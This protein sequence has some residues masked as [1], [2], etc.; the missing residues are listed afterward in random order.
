MNGNSKKIGY[1]EPDV[2]ADIGMA[3]GTVTVKR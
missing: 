1:A 3:G 2:S